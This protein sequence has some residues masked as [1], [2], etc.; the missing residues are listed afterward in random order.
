MG[1][2]LN[3]VKCAV[4]FVLAV[5]FALLYRTF[6]RVIG[7]FVIHHQTLPFML[8]FAR[9]RAL[10]SRLLPASVLFLTAK[11]TLILFFKI[12]F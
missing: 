6:D 2:N 11:V 9:L 7:S 5:I 10:F 12:L 1:G 8:V 4:V 3:L